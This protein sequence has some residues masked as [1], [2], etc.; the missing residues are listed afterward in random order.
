MIEKAKDRLEVLEKIKVLESKGE[1]NT[2]VENDTPV[3]TPLQPN[4]VDYKRKKLF[5]KIKR[6][7]TY[8]IT[9][10][11]VKKL[12]DQ[13]LFSIKQINGIENFKNIKTGAIITCN[14]FNAF[15][16]FAMDIAFHSAKLKNKRLFR[17]IKES[18]F[19]N[20][21]PIY[22]SMMR[23]CD[24]LP[25]SKNNETLKKFMQ[26]VNELL[27]EGNFILI[28]PEQSMWWNYKKPRPL[29]NGAFRFSIRNNVPII[30]VFITMK[31]TDVIGPDGFNVQE[32]YININKPLYPDPNLELK[33][34]IENLRDKNFEIWKNVYENFYDT[35]LTYDSKQ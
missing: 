2:D 13:G 20:P 26:S 31:D 33:D 3:T 8:K 21:P 35:K 18:N 32:Y 17:V 12:I 16:S 23:N 4:K 11:K 27:N 1:F 30:P 19:T 15:D 9:Q 10:K 5:N 7:I 34:N 29:R 25:L 22:K 6:F 24:T 28:Y 14:H